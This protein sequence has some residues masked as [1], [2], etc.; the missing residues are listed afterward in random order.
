MH[1]IQVMAWENGAMLIINNVFVI[2]IDDNPC[3][4]Q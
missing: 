4:F 1:R 3:V 2:V